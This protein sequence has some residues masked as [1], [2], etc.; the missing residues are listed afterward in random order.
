MI[1]SFKCRETEKIYLGKYSKK[2]PHEIQGRAM[3]K[4]I[5]LDASRSIND[6]RIPPSN[7]LES[8]YGDRSGQWS[9]RIND[10]YRLC[11]TW[12]KDGADAVE[13]VDYHK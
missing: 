8:L 12:S 4:L 5:M 13:I 7:R 10:Q 6:L 3:R 1:R 9:I 2:F 11:F